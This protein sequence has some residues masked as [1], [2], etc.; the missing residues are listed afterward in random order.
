M[1]N[2]KLIKLFLIVFIANSMLYADNVSNIIRVGKLIGKIT[3]STKAIPDNK[4]VDFAKI[5]KESKGTKKLGK[6]LGKMKLSDEVLEDTFIRLAIYQKKID[7]KEAKEMFSN[8]TNT[9]GFRTTSRKIIGNGTNKT[10]GH[11]NELKIANGAFKRG[12]KVKGIGVTFVDGIKK[13]PTDLDVLLTRKG[14]V[15]AIEAKDYAVNTPIPLDKFRGDMDTL[16]SYVKKN[17]SKKIIPIFSMT[18]KPK[19]AIKMKQLKKIA[20]EKKVELVFGTPEEQ[21]EQIKMLGE[22]L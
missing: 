3:K 13:S 15:F 12:F 2:K 1:V 10:A 19:S 21:I 11:I 6:L 5:L 16:A 9:K 20:K 14:K 8:L 22:I 18:N 17:P 4:I 7:V